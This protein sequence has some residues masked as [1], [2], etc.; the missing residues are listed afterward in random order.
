MTTDFTTELEQRLRDLADGATPP[1]PAAADD[2]GRGRR[3]LA[4]RRLAVGAV[5][6]TTAAVVAVAALGLTGG[7]D[8]AGPAPAEEGP[9]TTATDPTPSPSP[10]PEPEPVDRRNGRQLLTAWARALATH[11]D[12]QREHLQRRPDNLQDG[13]GLGTKLGWEVEGESGLGM[14]QIYVGRDAF[15]GSFTGYS[16]PRGPSCEK[17]T[18]DG[19]EMQVQRIDGT[20]GVYHVQPDGDRVFLYLDPLFGNNSLTPVESLDFPLRTLAAAVSDP[21]FTTP[22]QKQVD[23]ASASFGW[24]DY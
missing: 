16:C 22:T 13:Y 11:L 18:V 23:G 4:R 14:V 21:A 5:A 7:S 10:T 9:A 24:P 1:A 3:G 8:A 20:V 17:V 12:P 19:V 6:L 15:Q 2:L